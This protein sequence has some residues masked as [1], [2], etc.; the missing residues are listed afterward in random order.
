MIE[1]L[2]YVEII[3]SCKKVLLLDSLAIQTYGKEQLMIFVQDVFKD[4][5]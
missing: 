4:Y 3:T 5:H 2:D 1:I